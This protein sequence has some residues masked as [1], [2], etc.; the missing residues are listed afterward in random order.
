MY[1]IPD[2][3]QNMGYKQI[4]PYQFE[5]VFYS[6]QCKF[7]GTEREFAE[8]GLGYQYENIDK[9]TRRVI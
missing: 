8:K 2:D 7:T 6:A 5:Q 1:Q 4:K 3:A 9:F